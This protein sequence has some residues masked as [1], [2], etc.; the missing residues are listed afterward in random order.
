M[1][2]SVLV[3]MANQ[4]ADFWS[5]YPKAEAIDG[6]TKHIHAAWEPRMRDAMKAHLD[7]GGDGLSPLCREALVEY[8]KGPKASARPAAAAKPA[9]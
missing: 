1:K 7:G 6:I 4:I 2:A 5:P 9:N 3:Q 8:F